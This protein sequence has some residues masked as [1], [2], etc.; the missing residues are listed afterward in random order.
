MHTQRYLFLGAAL[1]LGSGFLV[2]AWAQTAAGNGTGSADTGTG[3]TLEEIVVT[4][5]KRQE[6]LQTTPIAIS[7]LN[8]SELATAGVY[9][10][11]RLQQLAPDV[12]ITRIVGSISIGIR[13]VA[14]L[15]NGPTTENPTSISI[16][17]AYIDRPSALDGLFF[18]LARIEVLKGPQGT[19][20]GRNSS[21]GAVNIITNDPT[22]EFGGSATVQGGNFGLFRGEGVLNM[23]VTDSFAL[24]LAV[25]DYQHSSYYEAS[26]Q[27]DADQKSARLKGLWTISDKSRLLFSFDYQKVEQEATPGAGNVLGTTPGV[28]YGGPIGGSGG[29]IP[30]DPWNNSAIFTP[31]VRSL[32]YFNVTD[33]GLMSQFDHEFDP[34]TLTIQVAH[35]DES[36]N[37]ASPGISA[38]V[39]AGTAPGPYVMEAFPTFQTN[40]LQTH[41]TTAEVRLAS[42]S[43]TPVQWVA[44][45]F[46][47][48]STTESASVLYLTPNPTSPTA[49]VDNPYQHAESYAAFGQATWTPF[50]PLHITLGVRDTNDYKVATGA[51]F[52]GA[53]PVHYTPGPTAADRDH[54]T[55][56][57]P[58]GKFG[59][60]YDLA[61]QSMVYADVARGYQSGGFSYGSQFKFEPETNLAYEVGTKNRFADDRVQ[62]NADLFYY[63]YRNKVVTIMLRPNPLN[64]FLV[65]LTTANAGKVM[66]RGGETDLL[67]AVTPVD[68]LHAYMSFVQA[69][70]LSYLPDTPTITSLTDLSHTPLVQ[71]E[72]SGKLDYTHS[73]QTG[74]GV[75]DWTLTGHFIGS[76]PLAVGGQNLCLG[77]ANPIAACG[78]RYQPI[79]GA[80]PYQLSQGAYWLA[81]TSLSFTPP[82]G[83]W[84]VTAFCNNCGNIRRLQSEAIASVNATLDPQQGLMTG[85]VI[86]PRTYSLIASAKF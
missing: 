55:F 21:G 8:S 78:A 57:Q 18:D 35:R 20:Y 63:D 9:D 29:G 68:R 37:Q 74:F 45:L 24:R 52:L 19:L 17:G 66:Y 16:D 1:F 49:A 58:S 59:V 30:S 26:D 86:L 10:F 2:P 5:E 79:L 72:W 33:W 25:R 44:G 46:S 82:S 67:W 14:P 39:V 7:S 60:A 70:Y 85:S 4:A 48:I 3:S 6:N 71:P 81:D 22:P 83:R 54:A 77:P 15:S 50:D 34:A 27:G 84:N 61:P 28:T 40:P 12:T 47:M 64:P 42:T 69:R 38:A 56:N 31:A 73:F 76:S 13:G 32:S 65:D 75:F 36:L 11:S 51:E 43:K 80:E 62:V 23:P 41:S 53:P